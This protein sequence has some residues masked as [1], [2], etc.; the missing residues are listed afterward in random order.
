MTIYY[1]DSSA[2]VKR[3]VAEAG[4]EAMRAICTNAQNALFLSELTLVE[5][6]SAFARRARGGGISDDDRQSYLDLFIGDCARD[7][8]L[9]PADRRAI[10]RAVG[11]TQ[12]HAL[13]EYDALQLA[14]AL[15]AS[16]LLRVAGVDAVQ[17]VSADDELSAAA[18]EEG[19]AVA[20]LDALQ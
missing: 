13:R 17:F 1:L 3:Y 20:K 10:D 4:S 12:A 18:A 15:V 8:A 19:L 16:D 5:V 11:L 7:Y 2:V 6:S 9:I 14:C